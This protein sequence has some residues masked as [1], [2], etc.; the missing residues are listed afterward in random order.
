MV[1]SDIAW[2]LVSAALVWL[3]VPGLALFYGGFTDV[4]ST[5]N[6][7]AMVLIAIAIGGTVWFAVGY[8]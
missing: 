7:L 4:R 2:V 1:G 3:M 5:V 6:T 8:S